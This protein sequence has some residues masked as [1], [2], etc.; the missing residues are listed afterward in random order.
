MRMSTFI[1]SFLVFLFEFRDELPPVKLS[2]ILPCFASHFELHC[3]M[4]NSN[5]TGTLFSGHHACAMVYGVV[6][7]PRLFGIPV[8]FASPNHA[9]RLSVFFH[10]SA[11]TLLVQD[12]SRRR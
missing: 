12:L 11:N 10:Y 4:H 7:Q 5:T 8:D 9:M 1:E 2:Q 3:S 6:F